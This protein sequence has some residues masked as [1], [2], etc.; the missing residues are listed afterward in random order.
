MQ[1]CQHPFRYTGLDEHIVMSE[2]P[3][4]GRRPTTEAWGARHGRPTLSSRLCKEARESRIGS[5][6]TNR[7]Q[8]RC[9]CN[10]S[11]HSIDDASRS[12]VTLL[13]SSGFSSR[14]TVHADL[15]CRTC[16]LNY[17]SRF[18]MHMP[19]ASSAITILLDRP[20][21][22]GIAAEIIDFKST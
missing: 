10:L 12:S 4:Y 9:H 20:T 21:G 1:P 15:W 7:L 8:L 11:A 16:C 17:F 19:M 14:N 13:K 18:W 6:L 3:V 2:E 22:K 5:G